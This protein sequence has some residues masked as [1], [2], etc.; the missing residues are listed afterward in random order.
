MDPAQGPPWTL[1]SRQPQAATATC[2]EKEKRGCRRWD[3]LH[4]HG[5]YRLWDTTLQLFPFINSPCLLQETNRASAPS[6]HLGSPATPGTHGS[7]HNSPPPPERYRTSYTYDWSPLRIYWKQKH[8]FMVHNR[9]AGQQGAFCF[10]CLRG[11]RPRRQLG[12][13]SA[14]TWRSSAGA[15]GSLGDAAVRQP[16][17]LAAWQR[18]SLGDHR[19]AV[20]TTAWR[21]SLPTELRLLP[22]EQRHNRTDDGERFRSTS[23]H[24]M[25]RHPFRSASR[26]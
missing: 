19:P 8:K 12:C 14:T 13:T 7:H 6:R 22:T 17:A 11:R 18:V 15:A 3:R 26:R 5:L 10:G 1:T 16:L 24:D 20:G 25:K 23:E 9:L 4:R 21:H 2:M